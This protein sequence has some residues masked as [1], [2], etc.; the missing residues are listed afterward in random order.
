MIVTNQDV[1]AQREYYRDQARAAAK[2]R[3]VR[4]ALESQAPRDRLGS[5]ALVW[6]GRHLV[7][8]GTRLRDR[9]SEVV[10]TPLTQPTSR[11]AYE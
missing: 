9:Y 5:R 2:Y 4:L 6:V 10:S 8:W 1:M 11:A 3:L 7:R